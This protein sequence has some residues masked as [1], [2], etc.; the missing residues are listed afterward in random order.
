MTVRLVLLSVPVAGD[1]AAK[2]NNAR[3]TPAEQRRT[4]N[5]MR[6]Q[7]TPDSDEDFF[8]MDHVS[9]QARRRRRSFVRRIL[10]RINVIALSQAAGENGEG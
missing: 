3:N 6:A 8:C 2:L 4:E 9:V 7:R 5:K 1:G 10:V